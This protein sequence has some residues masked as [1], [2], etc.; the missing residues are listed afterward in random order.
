M[1]DR[2]QSDLQLRRLGAA[3]VA[4]DQLQA[5]L[6]HLDARENAGL[7][8]WGDDRE[9]ERL[10][11]AITAADGEL[12]AAEIAYHRSL[13]DDERA[14]ELESDRLHADLTATNAAYGLLA[15]L[16][17]VRGE[18]DPTDLAA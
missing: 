6:D 18:D 1:M 16:R 3:S 4:R 12:E 7:Q 9:R 15:D 10:D 11:K 2:D 13:D 17:R 8:V 14:A 5:E